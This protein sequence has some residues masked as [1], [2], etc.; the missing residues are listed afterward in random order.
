MIKR[1]PMRVLVATA[2]L[3]IS[4]AAFSGP[5]RDAEAQI[6]TAYADYRAALM[7]T[8]QKDQPGSEAA[9]QAFRSKWTALV[10]AWRAVPPP[11]YADDADLARTLDAVSKAA[12]DA[13]VSLRAGNIAKS[14]DQLEV[15]RDALTDLRARNGV[16]S[17]SDRMNA[18]HAH[19]EHVVSGA[20]DNFSPAGL[21][22]L[23]EDAAVLA[24]L[25][26]DITSAPMRGDR[27]AFDEQ[28]RAVAASVDALR[29][30]LA[31]GDIEAVKKARAAIKPAY[32]RMF[33]R[34]G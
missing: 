6:A 17:F 7:K 29:Q 31:A 13:D 4:T 2:A 9:L 24:Y 30:A 20:Y 28:A 14:H 32:S 5:F 25:A 19:M 15:I 16:A 33:G 21:I 11:Q 34:F 23:R 12:D 10:T 27:A 18:Y 22:A 3:A 8:N 26:R 1:M